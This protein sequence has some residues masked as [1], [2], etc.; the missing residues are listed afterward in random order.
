MIESL[1]SAA[2]INATLFAM[3]G[4]EPGGIRVKPTPHRFASPSRR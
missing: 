1:K 4:V 2:A 3:Q